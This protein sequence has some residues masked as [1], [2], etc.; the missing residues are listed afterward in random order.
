MDPWSVKRM[1]S[2][3]RLALSGQFTLQV[4]SGRVKSGLV[5]SGRVTSGQNGSGNVNSVQVRSG[6]VRSC[7]VRPLIV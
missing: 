6:L 7:S 1:D 4:R 2:G 3:S 5:G